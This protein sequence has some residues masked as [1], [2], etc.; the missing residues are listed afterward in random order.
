VGEFDEL[1]T[2]TYGKPYNFQQQNDSQDRGTYYITVPDRADDFENDT[3]PEKIN[4]A[5]MGVSFAAWLARDP[6]EWN[7][8]QEDKNYVYRFWECNFYPNGCK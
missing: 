5:E 4:G 7:G 8:N 3:I 2:E 6:K 1:V